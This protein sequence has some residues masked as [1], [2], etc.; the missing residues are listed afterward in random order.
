MILRRRDGESREIRELRF[1]YRNRGV[2]LRAWTQPSC[3]PKREYHGV[4]HYG[5]ISM[6][7]RNSEVAGVLLREI[8]RLH[9]I[10]DDFT[11]T[12]TEKETNLH[13]L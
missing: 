7:W 4:K 3:E 1:L 5:K 11:N 9:G 8:D 13:G 6:N 12:K 2:A 10:I